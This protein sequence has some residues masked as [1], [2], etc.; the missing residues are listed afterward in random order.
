MLSKEEMMSAV[1]SRVLNDLVLPDYTDESDIERLTGLC[2]DVVDEEYAAYKEA[3]EHTLQQ[4]WIDW[5]CDLAIERYQ[6][7]EWCE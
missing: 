2:K 6:E 7:R 5:M 3:Y 4:Q 1:Q